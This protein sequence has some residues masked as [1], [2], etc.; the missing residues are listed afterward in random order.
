M[1]HIS[2]SQDAALGPTES[3]PTAPAPTD[4]APTD[5]TGTSRT[6]EPPP[7]RGRRGLH[8][9]GQRRR[10]RGH[11]RRHQ[12]RQEL[13]EHRAR[14]RHFSRHDP[15]NI[16]RRYFLASV[17][18]AAVL[19]AF[20]T[21]IAVDYQ[22]TENTSFKVITPNNEGNRTAAK[23]FP[24][25]AWYLLGGFR[26]S[27]RTAGRK[28]EALQ[29]AMNE[30][31][32][33][34]YIGYSNEGID[35]AQLFIAIL[36]DA[37]RR[38]ITSA[39]LYG[40][41]F[42]G[43]VAVVLAPLLEQNG[44]RVRMITFGSS[45]SSIADVRDPD[46]RYIPVAGAVVPYLGFAGRL[47]AGIWSGMTN[48]NGQDMYA[49][50]RSGIR[51]SFDSNANSFILSTS[52]GTFLRAF[53]SQYD[54]DISTATCM[55]LLYDP[56]DFIVNAETAIAGWHALLPRNT[57]FRYDLPGT[58]HASPEIAPAEYSTALRVLQDT[59]QPLPQPRNGRRERYF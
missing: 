34:S 39:Y 54:G 22:L 35:V 10:Q 29:A 20:R 14:Q 18:S 27:N 50:A 9:R 46:K 26:V 45:P 51:S 48:P 23:A 58:G 30:R 52:Q 40:D 38:K 21:N 1:S 31:A 28:L 55:G 57:F 17:G 24:G 3:R 11:R 33:A 5:G 43:M 12:R 47:A 2:L 7:T 25:A 32:P 37:Y 6:S 4:G 15:P 59:L 41:S 8:L 56:N 19:T 42:G 36:D 53:P 13:R 49:A 44:I 16:G